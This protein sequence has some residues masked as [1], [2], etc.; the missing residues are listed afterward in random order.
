MSAKCTF[1]PQ[2]NKI[3]RLKFLFT[4]HLILFCVTNYIVT[5]ILFTEIIYLNLSNELFEYSFVV[6]KCIPY[7]HKTLNYFYILYLTY[8][9]DFY[10]FYVNR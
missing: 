3:P 8:F 10:H 6:L 9:Y 4:T 5:T 7:R 1:R 2:E